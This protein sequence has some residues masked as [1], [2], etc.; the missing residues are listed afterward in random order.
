MKRDNRG[1]SWQL[2]VVGLFM[3]V[4]SIVAGLLV[5]FVLPGNSYL[6]GVL[7]LMSALLLVC[8]IMTLVVGFFITYR[9]A[10]AHAVALPAILISRLLGRG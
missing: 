9:S 6:S 2:K 8:G 10:I 1:M 5:T 4:A 7:L 3:V